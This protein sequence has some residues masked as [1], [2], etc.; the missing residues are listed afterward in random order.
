MWKLQIWGWKWSFLFKFLYFSEFS[1]CTLNQHLCVFFIKM[2]VGLRK[3]GVNLWHG[4]YDFSSSI[5]YGTGN[6]FVLHSIWFCLI[7]TVFKLE[8][9]SCAC[10]RLFFCFELQ[11]FWRGYFFEGFQKYFF[12][13]IF[14]FNYVLFLYSFS[15]YCFHEEYFLFSKRQNLRSVTRCLNVNQK[16]V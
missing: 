10:E 14:Y 8:F 15:F 16:A 13:L 5:P 3:G 6:S 4:F 12:L 11:F 2:V 1:V 9:L 7:V